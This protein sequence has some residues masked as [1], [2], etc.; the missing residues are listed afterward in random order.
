VPI[1]KT[2]R[3]KRIASWRGGSRR[4]KK[5]GGLGCWP[6]G[7]RFRSVPLPKGAASR[8]SRWVAL[9]VTVG[10]A[11]YAQ[12]L[13]GPRGRRAAGSGQRA[14][15][16]GRGTSSAF[17]RIATG[18][19][20]TSAGTPEWVI[21]DGFGDLPT[22]A[23]IWAVHLPVDRYRSATC[24]DRACRN[25]SGRLAASLEYSFARIP[26]AKKYTEKPGTTE[27]PG[28]RGWAYFPDRYTLSM[29]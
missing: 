26:R 5:A 15:G 17:W 3:R 4:E 14:A 10:L 27:L 9:V 25:A 22:A 11:G 12:A 24:T 1:R 20:R 16:S 7:Q 21:V 23:F 2:W 6:P 29:A 28:G 13:G 19:C 8:S 18:I